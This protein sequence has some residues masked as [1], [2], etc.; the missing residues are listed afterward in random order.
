MPNLEFHTISSPVGQITLGATDSHLVSLD[1]DGQTPSVDHPEHPILTQAAREL[2]QYFEGSRSTFGVPVRLSGTPFQEAI[3][4]CLTGISYGETISYGE[5]GRLAGFPGSAR[6]V[7]GA[8][9]ANPIPIIVPCHR[10]LGVTKRITGYSGGQGIP[11][12]EI[13]LHLENISYA[14]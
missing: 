8:V 10:V 13:L 11:T 1:I 12:K 6:A 4:R 2:T 5:L 9:G 14:A 7:G 3:W